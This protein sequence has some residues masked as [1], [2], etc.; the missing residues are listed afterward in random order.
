MLS[1]FN[2]SDE[3]EPVDSPHAN[4]HADDKTTPSRSTAP[5][6]QARLLPLFPHLGFHRRP[7]ILAGATIPHHARLLRHFHTRQPQCSTHVIP[8]PHPHAQ[9]RSTLQD[10]SADRRTTNSTT[11]SRA[12]TPNVPHATWNPTHSGPAHYS[13]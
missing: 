8:H 12:R 10:D 9:H 13:A 7:R 1:F 11:P 3:P 5:H 4:E 6:G 2:F